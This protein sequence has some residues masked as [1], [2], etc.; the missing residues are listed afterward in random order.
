MRVSRGVEENKSL[1]HPCWN[2]GNWNLEFFP[3][4]S[5]SSILNLATLYQNF[6]FEKASVIFTELRTFLSSYFL[7][8]SL[9]HLK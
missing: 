7:S 9:G 1:L 2:D 3:I 4:F 6:E 8:V 5:F